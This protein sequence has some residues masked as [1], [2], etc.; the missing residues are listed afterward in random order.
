MQWCWRNVSKVLILANLC[1][2]STQS[3]D[4]RK[5]QCTTITLE[6]RPV[7]RRSPVPHISMLIRY[8][9]KILIN[10]ATNASRWKMTLVPILMRCS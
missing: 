9:S 3:M 4:S 10:L 6:R 8:I 1:I 5:Y 2:A 7:C